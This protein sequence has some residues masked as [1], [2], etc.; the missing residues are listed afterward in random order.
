M[1]GA[2]MDSS[3]GC[4]QEDAEHQSA[5]A[6]ELALPGAGSPVAEQC[7]DHS[8]EAAVKP[9]VP[10]GSESLEAF[11]ASMMEA[12]TSILTYGSAGSYLMQRYASQPAAQLFLNYL[13]DLSAGDE[14]SHD[15]GQLLPPV[16]PDDHASKAPLRLPVGAFSYGLEA[17]LKPHA[18]KAL[19]CELAQHFLAD[20]FV[21]STEPLLCTQNGEI[22]RAATSKNLRSPW[23][24]T[25]ALVPHSVGYCKGK[26]RMQTLLALLS[27][28]DDNQI[29]LRVV[30]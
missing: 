15:L 26:A 20:G 4:K 10:V 29:D 14:A 27:I 3:P 8:F 18:D 6:K 21:T 11:K 16:K 23:R 2:S 28:C 1:A 12:L 30:F 5:H 22:L 9:E 17:S 25:G 24:L 7:T 19:T 13:H